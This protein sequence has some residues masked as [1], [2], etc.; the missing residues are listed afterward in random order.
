AVSWPRLRRDPVAR[1]GAAGMV[2]GVLPG[3]AGVPPG[4]LLALGGFGAM[5]LA[6]SVVGA[7]ADP[8]QR[9]E[10]TPRR[11]RFTAIAVTMTVMLHGVLALHGLPSRSKSNAFFAQ[12][13]ERANATV[14]MTE[15][16][17]EKT[18]VLVNPPFEPLA[19]YMS[20]E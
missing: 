1:F 20:F 8:A 3:C 2:L 10:L 6:A 15:A 12:V 13:F 18:V 16:V 7:F 5:A 9:G 17:R 14:R 4:R 19:W 11:R